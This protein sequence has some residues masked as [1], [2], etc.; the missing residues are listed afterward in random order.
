MEMKE[1]EKTE[2]MKNRKV[3]ELPKE[4]LSPLGKW[5]YDPNSKPLMKIIDMRAVLK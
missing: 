2:K 5:F 4:R 1:K 3:K